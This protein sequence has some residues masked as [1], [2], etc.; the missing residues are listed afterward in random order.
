MNLRKV[1]RISMI[2]WSTGTPRAGGLA[3]VKRNLVCSLNST[4]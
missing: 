1:D 4:Y 3:K 2:G